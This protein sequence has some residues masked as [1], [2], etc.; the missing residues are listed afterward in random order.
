VEKNSN[1]EFA[2]LRLSLRDYAM[3]ARTAVSSA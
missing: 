1:P 2:G 3:A